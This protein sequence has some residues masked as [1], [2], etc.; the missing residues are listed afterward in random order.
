MGSVRAH[1][2]QM[3]ETPKP[4]PRAFVLAA[5]LAAG[6]ILASACGDGSNVVSGAGGTAATTTTH[7]TAP[8]LPGETDCTVVET[9]SI[10]EP[11]F[12]HIAICTPLTYATNPPSGGNHWPIWGAF[13]K[14][15][16]VLPREMYV[17]D[18]EHGAIVFTYNCP[19]GC[20]DVVTAL[21]SVFDGMADPLCLSIPGGPPARVVLTPDPDLPTPIAA[22]AWG[23]TYTATCIDVPSL[24][25]F[26][27]ANYGKG[28]E[29]L[30]TDGV[31]VEA[32]P[33]CGPLDGGTGG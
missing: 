2:L 3:G 5:T 23:A 17:H 4:P 15:T 19:S 24:R 22:S 29:V 11:D 1:A 26:A 21:G 7:P 8:P 28:R 14:Y 30:C 10:P 32:S 12:N 13:K 25:A 33:P 31:D 27:N 16:E 18:L 20:P 9:T 6:A